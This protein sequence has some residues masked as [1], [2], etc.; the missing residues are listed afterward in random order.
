MWTCWKTMQSEF[1]D[2]FPNVADTKHD[3]F[4]N[5]EH[6]TESKQRKGYI[7]GRMISL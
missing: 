1:Y 5:I 2:K 3:I 7:Q 4:D 6:K